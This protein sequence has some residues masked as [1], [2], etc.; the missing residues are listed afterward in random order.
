[1]MMRQRQKMSQQAAQEQE[2]LK[3]R[4]NSIY[5]EDILN[6]AR[7]FGNRRE[8]TAAQVTDIDN[9][10]ITIQ[11]QWEEKKD[12]GK[13]S[14]DEMQ[15]AFREAI[16]A[17]SAIQ[18]ISDLASEANKALGLE[19]KPQLTKDKEALEART[20]VSFAFRPPRIQVMASVLFG[21]VLLGYMA[22]TE[23]VHPSLAFIRRYIISQTTCYYIFVIA[24][25]AHILEALAV[26]SVCQLIKTFQPRQMT[27][28]MQVKWTIGGALFGIFCLHDFMAR[29]MRQFAI[30]DSMKGPSLS[31]KGYGQN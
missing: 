4:L 15:F 1:M 14:T 8:A 7:H 6:I 31:Q 2:K 5:S 28:E 26:F 11:W 20:L 29:I 16:T 19:T 24:I 10:G 23:H 3:S 22:F 13:K 18:E 25:G 12:S 21:L 17:G 9:K 30:A 27:T